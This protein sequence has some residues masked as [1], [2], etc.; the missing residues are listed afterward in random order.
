MCS[1]VLM[2]LVRDE[3]LTRVRR[4]TGPKMTLNVD[5]L[6]EEQQEAIRVEGVEVKIEAPKSAE[7]QDVAIAKEV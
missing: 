7:A 6:S 3:V 4:F 2:I 1:C 5:D